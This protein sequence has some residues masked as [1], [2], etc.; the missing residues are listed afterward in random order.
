[1]GDIVMLLR[2]GVV[3]NSPQAWILCVLGIAWF[4]MAPLAEEPW[5]REQSGEPYEQYK[6]ELPRFLGRH[7]AA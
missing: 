3:F 1:V 4:V 7:D 5:L 6:R 2:W